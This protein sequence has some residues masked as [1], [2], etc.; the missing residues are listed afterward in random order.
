MSKFPSLANVLEWAK[1]ANEPTDSIKNLEKVPARLGMIDADLGSLS[2]SL[3]DY[4][5]IVVGKGYTLVGSPK[6]VDANGRRMDS[7]IRALLRRFWANFDGSCTASR[8]CRRR[9]PSSVPP[10]QRRLRP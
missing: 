4:E 3:V 10:P 9:T 7:R 8:G 2:A 6:D 5:R 1:E